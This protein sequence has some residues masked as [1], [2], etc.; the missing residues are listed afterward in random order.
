MLK[1]SIDSLSVEAESLIGKSARALSLTIQGSDTSIR[2]SFLPL[3]EKSRTKH[4]GA[5]IWGLSPFHSAFCYFS[6]ASKNKR[7]IKVGLAA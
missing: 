3:L 7:Q 6:P 5:K 1:Y 2:L 4:F